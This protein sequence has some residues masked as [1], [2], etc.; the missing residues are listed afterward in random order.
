MT[1][2]P[3]LCGGLTACYCGQLLEMAFQRTLNNPD[4]EPMICLGCEAEG[5]THVIG[6]VCQ[7]CGH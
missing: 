2:E 1:Y 4:P 3:C 6:T 5:H 7:S